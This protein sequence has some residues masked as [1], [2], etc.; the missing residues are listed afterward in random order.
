MWNKFSSPDPSEEFHVVELGYL[1][2]AL[3]SQVNGQITDGQVSDA[4][5]T[6]LMALVEMV[7]MVWYEN[8]APL[9]WN[10]GVLSNDEKDVTKTMFCYPDI[11]SVSWK[12]LLSVLKRIYLIIQRW[13]QSKLSTLDIFGRLKHMENN[14]F[15]DE[16]IL[17][18]N[19]IREVCFYEM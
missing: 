9:E 15:S 7:W 1:D 12:S 13:A 18:A 6:G 16:K 3:F 5:T 2:E 11:D 8:K 4:D 19:C 14:G 10:G 17:F